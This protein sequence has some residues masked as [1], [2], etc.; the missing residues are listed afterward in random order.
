MPE[1][2]VDT[3]ITASE[4]QTLVSNIMT[5]IEGA[6]NNV[7]SQVLA[8]TYTGENA[9]AF[10][11]SLS[12]W[13][14]GFQS[15]LNVGLKESGSQLNGVISSLVQQLGGQ[16]I[17]VTFRDLAAVNIQKDSNRVYQ[18]VTEDMTRFQKETT[19]SLDEISAACGKAVDAFLSMSFVHPLK[20]TWG[21][22]FDSALAPLRKSV[23]DN[24]TE[25]SAIVQKQ[26]DVLSK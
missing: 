24:T 18:A 14:A 20:A 22:Q 3:D 6:F 4:L 25:I 17:V 11:A 9:D 16:P 8:M 15:E 23:A 19:T 10:N 1:Y 12:E 21:S 2:K 5:S 7:Q 13:A 26:I